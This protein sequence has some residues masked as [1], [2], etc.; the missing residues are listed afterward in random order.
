MDAYIVEARVIEKGYSLKSFFAASRVEAFL[1]AGG[2]GYLICCMH[3]GRRSVTE[4]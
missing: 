1:R 2:Q 4:L 3:P